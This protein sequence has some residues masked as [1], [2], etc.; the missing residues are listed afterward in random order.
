[1]VKPSEKV[2][3]PKTL[4]PSGID[5][6]IWFDCSSDES[7]RRALGRRVD[8]ETNSVYHIQDNPPSIEKS[9]LCELILPIDDEK[10]SFKQK[11]LLGFN[12]DFVFTIKHLL[13]LN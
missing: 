12:S 7:L 3:P 6:V 5:A 10:V 13:K 11:L 2:K 4:I 8:P 1:M 9:P